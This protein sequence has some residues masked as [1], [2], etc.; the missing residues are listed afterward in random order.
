MVLKFPYDIDEI[1]SQLRDMSVVF[2]NGCFDIFHPGH[3]SVIRRCVERA[4]SIYGVVVIGVD[5][6][7]SV[8]SLKGSDRP[9]FPEDHRALML[10]CFR[11]VYMSVL[12]DS[13]RLLDLITAVN[14]V[15][16]VKGGDYS[17]DRVVSCGAPVE[18]VDFKSGWSTT[19]VIQSLR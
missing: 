17:H 15:L 12:F 10:S 16:V 13:E 7:R 14:P 6:D 9:V 3:L 11:G 19:S 4:E 5:T 8:A 2:T 18:I 1:R